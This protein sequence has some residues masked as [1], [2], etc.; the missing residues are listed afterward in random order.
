MEELDF[1]EYMSKRLSQE[2]ID[3]STNLI[4]DNE[5]QHEAMNLLQTCFNYYSNLQE[6]REEAQRAEDYYNG[7]QWN[8]IM[9]DPITQEYITE[10]E[11]IINQGRYPLKQNQIRQAIKNLLGQFRDSSSK[12]IVKSRNK[13]SA[14]ASEMFTH[15]L[16]Y[17]LHIN[18]TNELDV[19][20][21][22]EF[23]ISGL[24]TYK[25]YYGLHE[26]RDID[27]VVIDAVNRNKIGF[28]TGISDIRN[29]DIHTV[30]ELIDVYIDDIIAQ[31]ASNE[32]DELKIREW[33]GRKAGKQKPDQLGRWQGDQGEDTIDFYAT[34]DDRLR[35]YEVWEKKLE[36]VVRV[37]DKAKAEYY[38]TEMT[39]EEI[40]AIN[41]QRIDN[42]LMAG[43]PPENI[44]ELE[45]EAT[46]EYQKVWHFWFLTPNGHILRHG[47]TPYKHQNNPY[48][49]G[50]YPLVG[51]KIYGLVHD[52]LDQQKNINKL[53]TLMDFM[54]GSAAKGML[55]FPEDML[56]EGWDM[57]DIAAEYAAYNGVIAYKPN[58]KYPG[59]KPEQIYSNT[60]NA[61]AMDLLQ[62]QFS[63]L[64]KISGV[65]DAIQGQRPQAGTPASLYA[66]Q[67][68]NATTSNRDYFEF[69]F[70]KVKL[71]DY[72]IVKLIQ[73][74][75]DDNRYIAIGG[76]DFKENEQYYDPEL[77][78]DIEFDMVMNSI[79]SSSLYKE[80][81]NDYLLRFLETQQISF[82]EFLENTNMPFADKIKATRENLKQ[83]IQEE[84]QQGGQADPETMAMF[85]QML[86]NQKG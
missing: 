56:P 28:N 1:S 47:K 35:V 3:N 43:V 33:Y 20:Q 46:E 38:E 71:R 66:Q 80:M 26:D 29:K 64:E 57:E 63:L 68:Q 8:D 54:V 13:E 11:H 72:K 31:F 41:L 69:F 75:Y 85:E 78:Q 83:R 61:G 40:E 65:T 59:L 86:A 23:L 81:I 52:I 77:A 16:H 24:F 5:M 76:Q 49:L 53:I 74:F 42:A 37:H 18:Q 60:R 73:Q 55:L 30:F 48:T 2:Q 36:R 82:D 9:I 15:A 67:T 84:Q 39:L 62:M 50:I 19:R 10:G 25:T 17:A 14:K 6:F 32:A 21:F 34:H 44:H 7:E 58:P 51:G 12:S 45:I 70:S 79:P 22:E 4:D 27:D